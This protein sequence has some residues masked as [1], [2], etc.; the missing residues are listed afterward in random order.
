MSNDLFSTLYLQ[1]QEFFLD[2][3]AAGFEQIQA[4]GA[5]TQFVHL[6]DSLVCTIV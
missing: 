5:K 4:L 6:E 2:P 1:L 3:V